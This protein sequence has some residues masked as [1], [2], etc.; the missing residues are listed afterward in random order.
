MNDR[1]HKVAELRNQGLGNKEISEL[2]GWSYNAVSRL[3]CDAG[4]AGLTTRLKSRRIFYAENAAGRRL[5]FRSTVHLE[6]AGYSLSTVTRAAEQGFV[7]RG[8]TWR[9]R[10][11]AQ[12]SRGNT[13][14][15]RGV[16]QLGQVIEF[17]SIAE[18]NRQ[19]FIPKEIRRSIDKGTP[20]GGY[21]WKGSDDTVTSITVRPAGVS[22]ISTTPS[23]TRAYRQ[24]R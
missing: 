1:H 20:H 10:G 15:V 23:L 16:N 8:Y 6:A 21:L 2:T 5:L 17:V 18:A 4:K 3:L 14:P 9:E 13:R 11:R 24:P 22:G 7:Y 19:G 12:K